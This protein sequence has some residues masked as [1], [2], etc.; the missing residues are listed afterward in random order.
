MEFNTQLPSFIAMLNAHLK[1]LL[2]ELVY[3]RFKRRVDVITSFVQQW[4]TEL[5]F[6]KCRTIPSRGADAVATSVAPLQPEPAQN[7]AF[8]IPFS[9]SGSHVSQN[10]DLPAGLEWTTKHDFET[11]QYPDQLSSFA[12]TT[13]HNTTTEQYHHIPE[14]ENAMIS[15][16]LHFQPADGSPSQLVP[17]ESLSYQPLA[18]SD[19][20][21][22]SHPYFVPPS[23]L[24]VTISPTNFAERVHPIAGPQPSFQDPTALRVVQMADRNERAR[25]YLQQQQQQYQQSHHPRIPIQV[26][27]FHERNSGSPSRLGSAANINNTLRDSGVDVQSRCSGQ[28]PGDAWKRHLATSPVSPL[29]TLCDGTAG[30]QGVEAGAFQGHVP[31][32]GTFLNVTDDDE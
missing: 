31:E 32:C 17:A 28:G 2:G 9:D 11:R 7:T 4:M 16:Q 18:V 15:Q 20:T 3:Q 22:F 21:S 14:P 29:S 26:Q 12:S 5:L 19:A 1:A 24:P 8:N 13:A 23:L 30:N 6:E 10:Y 27:R 25:Q